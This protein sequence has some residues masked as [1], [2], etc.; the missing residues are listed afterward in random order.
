MIN[1]L[2]KVTSIKPFSQQALN[3]QELLLFA[4]VG[5]LWAPKP[6]CHVMTEDGIYASTFSASISLLEHFSKYLNLIEEFPFTDENLN[7][8][9]DSYLKGNERLCLFLDFFVCLFYHVVIGKRMR[10]NHRSFALVTQ[11]HFPACLFVCFLCFFA[12]NQY[13]KVLYSQCEG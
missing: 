13:Q 9:C 4:Q 2:S 8:P 7:G 3:Q 11:N 12:P 6:R 10:R 5:G 1:N